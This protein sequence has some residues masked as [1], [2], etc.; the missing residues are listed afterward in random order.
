MADE[1][2]QSHAQNEAASE[3]AS[4]PR[5]PVG[6]FEILY[7]EKC[8]CMI[9]GG[10]KKGNAIASGEHWICK[11]C[12]RATQGTAAAGASGTR[13][14]AV[15]SAP[16]PVPQ[17]A[18]PMRSPEPEP[19][20]MRDS[21]NG[22]KPSGQRI[23]PMGRRANTSSRSRIIPEQSGR[24]RRLDLDAPLPP[25]DG[26][27]KA[28]KITMI[29]VA[30]IAVIGLTFLFMSGSSNENKGNLRTESNDIPKAPTTPAA[31]KAAETNSGT[32]G[33]TNQEI[34][35]RLTRKNSPAP[36]PRTDPPAV[37]PSPAP[38]PAATKSEPASARPGGLLSSIGTTRPG[39]PINTGRKPVQQ[40]AQKTEPVAKTE[41]EP[42]VEAAPAAP[43]EP[44]KDEVAAQPE[45]K[46]ET[47]P[48]EPKKDEPKII[49][50]P[51]GGSVLDPTAVPGM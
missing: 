36:A 22:R 41:P 29:A 21:R 27:A 16:A 3:P 19:A 38:P 35:D 50:P 9:P 26:G 23:T 49:A 15:R 6:S 11:K 14:T 40:P 46:T 8:G 7:C 39:E 48:V 17:P 37:R 10:A 43:V 44:K 2:L 34:I 45:K 13:A 20:E 42:V 18:P 25:A 4:K 12:S 24:G 31:S 51:S 47:P 30:A 33:V 5:I 32:G 1:T 28:T